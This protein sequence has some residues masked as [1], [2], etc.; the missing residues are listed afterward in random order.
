M[1]NRKNETFF[2]NT[3]KFWK[4]LTEPQRNLMMESMVKKQFVTGESMRSGSDNCSGLFLIESGQVRAYIVSESGKEITLYRLFDRDVCIFSA[5]CMMKN[6]T[7]DVFIE[8]EKK[9]TAFLIPI[10]VFS[11][12]SKES[13]A[14][15]AFTNELMASRFSEVMWIME[16]A[17]FMKFDKRLAMFLLEQANI[18]GSDSLEIT[19]E[20]IANHLGTA[21][22]V[23]TRMLKY[24]QNEGM[25]ALNRGMIELLD[26]DKLEAL[27]EEESGSQ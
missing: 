13:M 3:L 14:V 24:F 23:V 12:L 8:V 15:M 16:Q 17:L 19:H 26:Q 10:A 6:I 9:T 2:R 4:D 20:R 18:E 5:S 22:E 21:R 11:K 27:T 7:F 25:V 1:D